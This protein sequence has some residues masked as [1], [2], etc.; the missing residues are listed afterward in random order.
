MYEKQREFANTFKKFFS[1]VGQ[2]M[3][4][5]KIKIPGIKC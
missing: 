3:A 4:L 1:N 5:Q 2:E